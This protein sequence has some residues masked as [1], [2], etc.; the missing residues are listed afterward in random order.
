MTDTTAARDSEVRLRLLMKTFIVSEAV[1]FLSL[2]VTYASFH[3]SSDA[4]AAR[5]LDPARTGIASLLL[6]ASSATLAPA[7]ALLARRRRGWFR[8]SVG[9]TI[10]LGVAFLTMQGLEWHRL[11][12][13]GT[14]VSAGLFGATFFTLTGF[15][16]AHV[17]V[18]LLALGIVLALSSTGR[19]RATHSGGVE[20][21]A[22]Y[23]HFVDLVWVAVYS[24][25]YLRL[26]L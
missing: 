10:C 3:A 24:V 4:Q 12:A 6:I 11:L 7:S 14:G 23:W 18:G 26:V 13:G 25:V 15:H 17:L 22:I 2:I 20:A 19:L 8:L 1:F 5:L 21:V 16:G 9:V